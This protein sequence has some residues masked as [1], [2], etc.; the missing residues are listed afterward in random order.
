MRNLDEVEE[1]EGTAETVRGAGRV[2]IIAATYEERQ[3][4]ILVAGP[5]QGLAVIGNPDV[6]PVS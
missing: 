5:E 1:M 3:R 6:V 2:G 4:R